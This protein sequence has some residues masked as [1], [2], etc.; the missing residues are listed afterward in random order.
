MHS[1]W[2][3]MAHKHQSDAGTELLTLPE[4]MNE[5]SRGQNS[6][7]LPNGNESD[8][9]WWGKYSGSGSSAFKVLLHRRCAVKLKQKGSG[10]QAD[11]RLGKK[12]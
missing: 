10:S 1:Q 2:G 9:K 6:P 4:D 12:G 3:D 7:R 5:A 8:G 11:P